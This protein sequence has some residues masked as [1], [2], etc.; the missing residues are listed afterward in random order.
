MNNTKIACANVNQFSDIFID[1]I[2][3]HHRLSPFYHLFPYIENYAKQ[4]QIKQDF[5][6][7]HRKVLHQALNTQYA[8]IQ[9]KPQ[10]TIDLLLQPNTFTLT[11]GHQLNI[12]TGPLYFHFKIIT[13]INAAKQLRMKY[14]KYNFVPVYWM[15]S[16]DHDFEEISSFHLF[17]KK[18]TWQTNQKGAVGRF[19]PSSLNE[20]IE[21]TPEMDSIFKEAY[22]NSQTLADATR[23]IVNELYGHEGLLVIDGDDR[24]LKSL[25]RPIIQQEIFEH[26][27]HQAITKTNKALEALGYSAQVFPREINLF[28]LDDSLR[29]R[30]VKEGDSYK[31]LNTS[32]SFSRSEISQLIEV[33]PEKFSPNVTLRPVYQEVILPNLSYTGG[34]GELAYW[35]QLKEV[36]AY[37][38][39]PF[40][41]LLPRNFAL[42]LSKAIQGRMEKLSVGIHDLFVSPDEFKNAWLEKNITAPVSLQ[43]EIKQIEH[44]FEQMTEKAMA[45]DKSLKEFVGAMKQKTLASLEQ[46]EGKIQKAQNQKFST[47]TNQ[48]LDLHHKLFPN[49]GLQERTDNFLNFYLN[50]KEFLNKIAGVLDPFDFNFNVITI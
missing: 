25:F 13:V 7:T 26:P 29:E 11:T 14:P 20:V 8:S 32:L 38:D 23:Y 10:L 33:S 15:A 49:G 47:E 30:I 17:W 36:F 45:H 27:T 22:T 5:P 9:R 37:F 28:Y 12:F 35:L 3:C 16:E 44:I 4:I 40:P 43:E 24:E 39:V 21:Q 46:I 6:A 48:L 34:P 2:S 31:V 42:I 19:D 1:Y 50:D 18:Y 41:I